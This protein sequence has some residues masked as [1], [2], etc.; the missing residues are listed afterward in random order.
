MRN[1][2]LF[3]IVFVSLLAAFS[4]AAP[5]SAPGK[6][7]AHLQTLEGYLVDNA[8]ALQKHKSPDWA[9]KH[10]KACLNMPECM[11]SGYAVLTPD[12]KLYRFDTSGNQ[13]ARKL[14]DATDK[15][16]DWKVKVRGRVHPENDVVTVSTLQLEP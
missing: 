9:A 8:C 12:Q 13:K 16:S 7:V 2:L 11:K 15:K 10:G 4:L 1:R 6:T 3:A 5:H 14:I